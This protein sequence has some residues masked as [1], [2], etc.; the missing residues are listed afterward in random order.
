MEKEELKY[1][2]YVDYSGEDPMWHSNYGL[3]IDINSIDNIVN[4]YMDDEGD[5]K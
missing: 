1:Y 5:N 3:I 2:V 4:I